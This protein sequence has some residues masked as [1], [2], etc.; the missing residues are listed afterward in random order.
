VLAGAFLFERSVP[1]KPLGMRRAFLIRHQ[2]RVSALPAQ[3]LAGVRTR[4]ERNLGPFAALRCCGFGRSLKLFGDKRSE[5][6]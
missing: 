1:G 2:R 4:A 6:G 5:W 3:A